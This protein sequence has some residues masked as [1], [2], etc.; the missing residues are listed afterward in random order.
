MTY[1]N[2]EPSPIENPEILAEKGSESSIADLSLAVFLGVMLRHPF[3]TFR[4]LGELPLPGEPEPPI[5][6]Q[7]S[8]A[9]GYSYPLTDTEGHDS[10]LAPPTLST[11]TPTAVPPFP[12]TLP[13]ADSSV[14]TPSEPSVGRVSSLSSD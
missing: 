2:Y 13:E 12:H 14:W 4:A 3:R 6:S 10:P 11:D 7:S 9:E 1:S 8:Y 5:S